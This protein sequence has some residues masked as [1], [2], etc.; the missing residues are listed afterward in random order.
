MA[1]V[2]YIDPRNTGTVTG[3]TGAGGNVGAVA[4]GL[5]F[6]QLSYDKAFLI[7]GASVFGST[8]LSIFVNIPGHSCLLWGKDR[9]V[10]LETGE[11]LFS[12]RESDV[13]GSRGSGRSSLG[14]RSK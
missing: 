8:L 10:N 13:S 12:S 9:Q 14:T 5:A 1:I 7:M 2:P 4:F 3:I 11:L 6:R